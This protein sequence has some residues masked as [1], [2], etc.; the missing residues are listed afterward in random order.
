MFYDKYDIPR[1]VEI[2]ALIITGIVLGLLFAYG[3]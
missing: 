3:F 2:A 1:W